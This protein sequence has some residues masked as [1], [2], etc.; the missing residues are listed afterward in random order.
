MSAPSFHW[1]KDDE[2]G[3]LRDDRSRP[4]RPREPSITYCLHCDWEVRAADAGAERTKRA[5]A[6]HAATGHTIDS[7]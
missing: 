1:R 6:H 4:P 7:L 2:T 3:L 5:V